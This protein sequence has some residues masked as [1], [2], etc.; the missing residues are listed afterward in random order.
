MKPHLFTSIPPRLRG[1]DLK[2]SERDSSQFMAIDSWQSAGFEPV[3]IN[4]TD[5]FQQ[6][7]NLPEVLGQL[8]V[9]PLAVTPKM[10]VR[11]RAPL[12]PLRDFL[13]AIYTHS[14]NAPVAI[15]NAD[16][17]LAP[18]ANQALA[19]RV[20]ALD[21]SEFLIGQRNDISYRPDGSRLSANIHGFGIDFVAFHTSWIPKIT[22]A[23]SP[24]LAIGLPWWDHYL[25]LSLCAYGAQTKLIDSRWFE[26]DVH[27]FQWNWDHYCRIGKTATATFQRAM[28][29]LN[30]SIPAQC[31]L[32]AL[33]H[34]AYH[35]A[36]PA[37]LAPQMQKLSFHNK[38][39][40][41]VAKSS[42]GRLAAANMRIILQSSTH[43]PVPVP[44]ATGPATETPTPSPQK[45]MKSLPRSLELIGK[46]TRLLGD[47]KHSLV[48][49]LISKSRRPKSVYFFTF[50][51]C[52]STLFSFV[53]LKRAIGL[54]NVNYAQQLY[55]GR[56]FPRK[57][58]TFQENG[59]IYGPIRVTPVFENNPVED[60]LLGPV[61]QPDFLKSKRA[62][63]LVRD[64]R[65]ILTSE[66]F[67]YGFSHH[68]SNNKEVR[69]KQEVTR[70]EIQKATVD[71]YVLN[72]V[73]KMIGSFERLDFA[74]SQCQEKIVLRYE[75]LVEDFDNFIEQLCSF[76]PLRQST[77][78]LIY[79][80]S[81]PKQVE[82]I[83]SHKRSGL[84]SGFRR[85]LLPE[86]IDSL[87]KQLEPILK[88]FA[89]E[90]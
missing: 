86:T 66:Y 63:F 87:N 77:I 2:S 61:I 19:E 50:H 64:P 16:I 58:F 70:Q 17:R 42:L 29:S 12:C 54:R 22:K 10:R 33:N 68:L 51:K 39:P 55:S 69:Q 35:P 49:S 72:N 59:F 45:A 21:E 28:L 3:S 62:V 65:A 4:L 27:P 24:T 41:F 76:I 40:A 53:V 14:N 9:E 71:S 43:G 20:A 34:E 60:H 25:P 44:S 52:A 36:I 47:Y 8:G 90:A 83:S 5:E 81:R 89:Y 82:E 80:E 84:P 11:T 6:H 15:I 38:S 75:D 1:V 78:D 88:R 48:T 23:L 7:P 67:S 37:S 74:Q 18:S 46:G 73:Q 30:A 79:R 56:S 13:D 31:W 32:H 85:K 26:H 57:P